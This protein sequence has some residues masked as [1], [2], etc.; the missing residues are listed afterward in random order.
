MVEGRTE[1]CSAC[2]MVWESGPFFRRE[3]GGL[4]GLKQTVCEGC[5]PVRAK[6]SER[7]SFIV[8]SVCVL[9]WSLISIDA[10]L[11]GSLDGG[12][13]PIALL[14]AFLSTPIAISVH[15]AGHALVGASLGFLVSEVRIGSGHPLL[16]LRWRP[17]FVVVG[18]YP[19]FGGYTRFACPDGAGARVKLAAATAGG[20]VAN[21]VLAGLLLSFSTS[22]G[23]GPSPSA[24]FSAAVCAG[25]ALPNL[26]FGFFNLLPF[27]MRRGVV[28][29]S[30]GLKLVNLVR[31]PR[32]WHSE[33]IQAAR[34]IVLFQLGRFAEAI[35]VASQMERSG[36]L[37]ALALVY[38]AIAMARSSGASAALVYLDEREDEIV[39]LLNA[40]KPADRSTARSAIL[41]KSWC[42][43]KLGAT[44]DESDLPSMASAAL[45]DEPDNPFLHGVLG[46][47]HL[48]GDRFDQAKPLLTR[49][50]R[51]SPDYIEKADICVFL[52]RLA[53]AEGEPWRAAG[54]SSLR[55]HLLA[56][57]AAMMGDA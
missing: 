54:Y 55:S 48:I 5:D 21:L 53:T 35:A 32:R 42:A 49:A 20:P 27:R 14:S 1:R 24:A 9:V 25:F 45:K 34:F 46:A 29:E 19:V 7:R 18:R 15:E 22:I 52:S 56:R 51:T 10:V 37:G 43:I 11:S 16:V 44:L 57:H 2:S 13:I 39:R 41:F 3:R 26:L 50:I 17:A 30:D 8:W 33:S 31:R 4:F 40:D 28:N 38:P 6:P 47:W 23:Q 36:R 12:T